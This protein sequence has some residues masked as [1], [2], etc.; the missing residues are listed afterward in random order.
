M[1]NRN[2]QRNWVQYLASIRPTEGF[3][4]MGF[5]FQE[6]LDLHSIS[7]LSSQPCL[8]HPG[9]CASTPNKPSR[10]SMRSLS[11]V[12]CSPSLPQTDWSIRHFLSCSGSGRTD[13]TQEPVS[14]FSNLQFNIL[15]NNLYLYIAYHMK[16]GQY[17]TKTD[18]ADHVCKNNQTPPIE[19]TNNNLTLWANCYWLMSM[20]AGCGIQTS[21]IFTNINYKCLTSVEEGGRLLLPA[22]EC[23]TME[24]VFLF[25]PWTWSRLT[26]NWTCWTVC[27]DWK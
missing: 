3:S 10:Q 12:H 20:F 5:I 11:K 24:E 26:T 21:L 13:R 19:M 25:Q 8:T 9:Q 18:P 7:Q 23:L 1:N 17:W 14:K 27:R 4:G 15:Y 16:I 6:S 2:T 22:L